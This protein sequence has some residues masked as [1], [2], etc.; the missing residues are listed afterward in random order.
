MRSFI[1]VALSLAVASAATPSSDRIIGG[2]VT[3]INQYPEM[4]QLLQ[5]VWGTY[6]F[7]DCG[8]IILNNRA[9][10]TAAHCTFNYGPAARRV[11]FG[12]SYRSSGGTVATINRIINHPNYNRPVQWDNDVSIVWI[13]GNIPNTATS[14]PALIAGPN[15]FLA[16]NQVVWAA[17]WGLT[18]PNNGDSFSNQLRHVQIWTVNQGICRQRYAY[19]RPPMTVTDNMLCSGWLDVGGRDQCQ[20]DSGGPLYHNGVV[21]G[22]CSWGGVCGSPFYPGVN[23]R[24]SRYTNWINQN[25]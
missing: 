18:I 17:G 6:F 22:V 7:Q 3:T 25:R 8:G 5:V 2:S 23:A 20:G 16:D 14:R 13:N 10:L 21:V 4:A 12:S 24:V 15:Y 19:S 11:R 9:I 1:F